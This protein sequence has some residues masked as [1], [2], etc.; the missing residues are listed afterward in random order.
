MIEEMKLMGKELHVQSK[1]IVGKNPNASGKSTAGRSACPE[2]G[3]NHAG[4]CRKASG[5]CLSC[6]S[7]DH[8]VRDCPEEDKR[9]KDQAKEGRVVVCYGCNE[10]G[11]YKD[12]CPHRQTTGK[13]ASEGP[14]SSAKR[15]A[16][17][18]RVYSIGDAATD[19]SS[20]RPITGTLIMG[21]VAAHVLFDSG[22]S[23]CFV[24]PSLV[25]TGE[26]RK[27][28]GEDHGMVQAA[29]GQ[30][31]FTLGK[32][33]NVSVMIGEVNMPAD[34]VICAVKSYDVILEMDWL[35]K[36]KA[37][38]DCH[39]GRVWFETEKGKLK[40]QGVRPTAGSLIIS[41]VQADR[42]IEKGCEAYLAAITTTEVGKDASLSEIPVVSEF[43]DVF[44]ALS[45]LPP[46][47]SDPFT[48]ELEPGTAPV[49]K[50]SYR[51]A[52]AEMAELKKQL[53][54]L[55]EKGFVRPSSSPWGAPVLFVKK[56]DG[57]FRLCI[58]YRGLNRVTVKNKYPLPRID[59][60][61]D[62]LRGATW[63]SKI[64][65]ASGYHQIPIAESDV[66][67]TAFRTRYGH[68]E[69][70]VM[71]FGLTNA[72]AAFM[73][74]MNNVFR[75]CL[76][77]FVIIFIDDIL[78]YSKSPEEHTVHLSTVMKRLREH[79][80]F[81]KL[82]KC[83]FW[84]R[85]IGFLG[86]VVSDKGVSVD[87]EKIKSIAEWP[88]PRN[89]SEIRSFLGL[90]GYYRRFVK[91]FASMASPMTRLT[92][93]DV[94]FE[95]S[96]ECEKCFGKLKDMLTSTPVLTIPRPDEPYT[97]YTDASK[98]GLGC[99]LM[100]HGSVIAYGSRQLRKHECNYPTHDLEMAAVVFALKIWKPYLYGAKVQVFTDHKSLKYIFTQPGLNMRQQRWMESIAD[101][102]V[103]IAYHPG[104]ANLVADALSRKRVAKDSDKDMSGLVE[105]IG[106]LRLAA[107]TDELEP[108]GLG[109]ADQADLLTRVRLAQQLDEELVKASKNEQTEYQV[110]KNGT[111]VVHGRV[112]VPKDQELRE[113]ILKEAHHSKFSIHPGSTKMYQDLKRYYHWVV[114]KRDVAKWIAGCQ[115][116]QMVKTE[117]EVPGG[118]LQSLPIPE[119]KWD[120]ITMDFVTGLPAC[121]KLDAIWVIVDRLTKSAHFLAIISDRDARF[122][123]SFW[124]AFQKRLGTKVHMSTAYHPQT[125]GQSERTIRTLEDLLRTCVLDWG[126]KWKDYLPLA[127]F[128]YN[129][130]FQASI[131]MSPYEALYGR[132]CRTPLCWTQVGERSLYGRDFVEET[133]ERIRVLKLKMKEAQ[134]RQKSYADKHRRELEFQAGD[135]VFVKLITFKGKDKAAATGKLKPRYMGPYKVLERIG[136]VAY[137]LELPP[138]LVAFHPVF[139]V[140]LLRRRVTNGDNVVSE[141]PPDLQENL[142]VEGRPV[143]IVGRRVKSVG[144]KRI[145]MVQVVWDCEGE[146]ETTWEPESRM[147]EKFSKWF[148]KQP[149]APP[150]PK[151]GKDSRANPK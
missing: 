58:D 107:L 38:L 123:S 130:S 121:G 93:K 11:H 89:A 105:M 41:A 34:L 62:Q 87:P 2:C 70:V 10:T 82:S 4:P 102:D 124:R 148:E 56:K 138:A 135:M 55:M 150:K 143:R 92:G 86:H 120:M 129:N 33:R 27:E 96:A 73:K 53:N 101:F 142:T 59:E 37:H 94:W 13:R 117:H 141:P 71:P 85:E 77:E 29:S 46:D 49:S 133:T 40:Y 81:A 22:A 69:F 5:A 17:T 42:M 3:K 111:I 147:E 26:F 48:I 75:D 132:P 45:G 109:A 76:D 106:T 115:T 1:N 6:G 21:G 78:I 23:H 128:S 25:G 127:E 14:D 36:H 7:Q 44:Q 83:S 19:P 145:K 68:Y 28:P 50:A 90:A 98:T 108:L 67:K 57:S 116:C 149:K 125:D 39:R 35:G 100:Q 8:K 144:R 63:F 140:S 43:E 64:D 137:K 12:K 99:V 74:L 119:W 16:V 146:E 60:L 126:G 136:A 79:H 20:S 113:E 80:L 122:S 97:V 66:R 84:Q 104:K 114:M 91:G 32:I 47:R 151:K 72:P 95:L 15:Q 24:H 30:V 65:L 51:M 88:R 31:M 110:S 18:P 134:D 103:D 118:L 52:P 61:L 139:H 54:D 131:G 9:P 112:C